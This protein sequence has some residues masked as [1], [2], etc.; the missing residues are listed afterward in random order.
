MGETDEP[1]GQ[2]QTQCGDLGICHEVG[3][4]CT[5]DADEVQASAGGGKEPLGDLWAS[6]SRSGGRGRGRLAQGCSGAEALLAG[7]GSHWKHLG[8]SV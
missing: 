5:D 7:L 4:E 1:Q 3:A 6:P 2:V 8:G